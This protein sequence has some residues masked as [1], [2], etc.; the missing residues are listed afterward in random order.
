MN[1]PSEDEP[2][3]RCPDCQFWELSNADEETGEMECVCHRLPPVS[4]LDNDSDV[5]G[6]DE[7]WEG[8]AAL[9]FI[10]WAQAR[11]CCHDWCGEFVEKK[12]TKGESN[13]HLD[14]SGQ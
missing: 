2:E 14:R 5:Y 7:Q 3:P 12:N 6:P 9:S 1:Y 4:V 8:R 13:E 10:Y 11:V